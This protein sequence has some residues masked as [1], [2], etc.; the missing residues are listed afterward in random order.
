V[1]VRIAAILL[2]TGIALAQSIPFSGR[3]QSVGEMGK[4][5]LT[6]KSR[7]G[8]TTGNIWV[9]ET[10]SGLEIV[11]ALDGKAPSYATSESEISSRDHVD[12][13]LS[14]LA[15]I[16]SFDVGA[17]HAEMGRDSSA[18]SIGG[19]PVKRDN[20]KEWQARQ[21]DYPEQLGRLFIRHWSLAPGVAL[22]TYASDAYSAALYYPMEGQKVGA[23]VPY[24]WKP[25]VDP[26]MMSASKFQFKISIAWEGFPPADSLTLSTVYLVV[27]FCAA[28]EACSS[29]DPNRDSGS[30]E[31][32]HKLDLS[33]PKVSRNTECDYPLAKNASLSRSDGYPTWYLPNA[34]G[35]VHETITAFNDDDMY[36][37][38]AKPP[39]LTSQDFPVL[40]L[41]KTEF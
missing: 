29:T 9:T 2:W 22:E 11:G 33:V 36:A 8:K 5:T 26:N 30:P 35:V 34:S 10:A 19:V 38:Y 32:F 31:T 13:W 16:P 1:S 39:E 27:E 14:S 12:V 21:V 41:S 23:F 20:C 40:S 15:E 4:P 3:S 28:G 18:D 25:R 37:Q 7:A 24:A 6:L 17:G